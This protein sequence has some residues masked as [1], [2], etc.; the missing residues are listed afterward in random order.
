[1]FV[2]L[3]LVALHNV[4]EQDS[5][6]ASSLL[7]AAQ[8]IGGAIGLALLGTV[9]WTTVANSVRTQVAHAAAA[10][11]KAGRPLPKPGTAPP[12]S[13]YDHAL[14]VGFSR[15]FVVAA[16]IGVLAVLIAIA[17]IRVR[18]EELSGAAPA[19]QEA[20]PQPTAQQPTAKQPTAPQ[21][22]VPQTGTVQLHEDRAALAAAVR[23]CRLC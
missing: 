16:G 12:V 18:R 15:A 17:T 21:L 6:V 9:A 20:A 4:A 23:P 3:A 2:P 14:T 8:Q 11:A 13:I 19:P 5:G 1:V 7:N 10:A 22:A